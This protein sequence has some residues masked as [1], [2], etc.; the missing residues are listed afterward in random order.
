MNVLLTCAGRRN[1]LINAFQEALQG[2]GRVY[3]T[4]CLPEAPALQEADQGFALPSV[5]HADYADELLRLCQEEQIGL[6]VPLNDLELPRLS[7]MTEQL[8]AVG[9]IA[10][11]ASPAVIDCCS[12]KLATDQFLRAHR[13]P[14]PHTY[15][16]LEE[17]LAKMAC[18]ISPL[19][20]IVKPRWGSGSIGIQTAA[21]AEELRLAYRFAGKAVRNSCLARTGE[22][23][24]E[25]CLLI[26]E[27]ITGCEYGL[28]VIN[29]L[30]GR[31]VTTL[32]KRKLSMRAGETD[33]AVTVHD[34]E[35]EAL[36]E[37]LGKALCH[38]GNLDCDVIVG[39]DGPRVIELNPR[40]GGSYPFAH[41]AGANLPA[42]LLA[43]ARGEKTNLAWFRMREN[44]TSAK[45]DRLVEC[46]RNS[47]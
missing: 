4:D 34:S 1:Y 44:V 10:V 3:A 36:G 14:A 41:Q 9:T 7:R 2:C 17:V 12:D 27:R 18:S 47:V 23:Q 30:Q 5:E 8:R 21:D 37:R 22:A 15:L 42:A 13:I 45:C 20:V 35:L 33:R 25:P 24:H 29:D 32:V 26:Q 11:I 38:V 39:D 31:Y 43:W 46:G 19:S 40:F 28:D 6:L 16:A